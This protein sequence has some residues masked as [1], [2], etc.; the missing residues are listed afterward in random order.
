M[1][2]P[3]LRSLEPASTTTASIREK[4][5]GRKV[6]QRVKAQGE[7]QVTAGRRREGDEDELKLG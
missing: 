4:T 2:K 7:E 3:A 6:Q 1:E 5:A